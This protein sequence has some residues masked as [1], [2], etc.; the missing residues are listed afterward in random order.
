[1]SSNII[2]KH[3]TEGNGC[4]VKTDVGSSGACESSEKGF[5]YYFGIVAHAMKNVNYIDIHSIA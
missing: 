5:L 3:R 2:W 4:S 1:M